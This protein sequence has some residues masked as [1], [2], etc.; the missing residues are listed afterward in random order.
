[1]SSFD[2][3]KVYRQPQSPTLQDV[4][5][6]LKQVKPKV[7]EL[8]QAVHTY[9]VTVLTVKETVETA[10]G[11]LAKVEFTVRE[12]LAEVLTRG[13][14]EKR[15]AKIEHYEKII[16]AQQ[17]QLSTVKDRIPILTNEVRCI[18]TDV[19]LLAHTW[20]Q[21][22][23]DC[24]KQDLLEYA[25]TAE[26]LV[27]IRNIANNVNAKCN[28]VQNSID[29]V[30]YFLQKFPYNADKTI[31]EYTFITDL[32]LGWTYRYK[33]TRRLSFGTSVILFFVADRFILQNLSFNHT[34]ES[35]TGSIDDAIGFSE[36]SSCFFSPPLSDKPSTQ[37]A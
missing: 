34:H 37:T 15:I 21:A 24:A 6:A 17:T 32:Q 22:V 4:V 14:D 25:I 23:T 7:E 13:K 28:S 3:K 27:C 33:G 10:R 26:E 2:S 19:I 8:F 12:K 30:S 11:E 31:G 29:D 35:I 9:D 5:K 18:I 1:M 16:K 36:D 20:A